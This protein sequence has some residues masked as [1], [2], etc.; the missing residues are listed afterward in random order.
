MMVRIQLKSGRLV[1][2]YFADVFVWSEAAQGLQSP[3]VI[4]G[5]DEVIEVCDQLI[6]AVVMIALDPRFLDGAV[7]PLDL[8]VDPGVFD[9]GEPV[10]DP[11]LTTPHVEHMRHIGRGRTV[12]I[13]GR[14]CELDAVIRQD[15]VYFV[16]NSGNR[17]DQEGRG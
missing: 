5:V 14:I 9:F 2:P 16:G 10:L 15:G 17:G 8:S 3:A 7:Y 1:L 13:A 6:V 4:V 11:V 12:G